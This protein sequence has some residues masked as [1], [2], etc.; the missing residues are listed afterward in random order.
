VRRYL[1]DSS[2]LAA[3]LN[4]RP[5]AVNL[6]QPWI[7]EHEAATSVLVYGEIVEYVKGLAN[8]E[9]RHRELRRLLR[10][11]YPYFLTFS[12][13]EIYADIRRQLRPPYGP[14]IIGDVDSLIAA[15]A[16]QQDL[17]LVTT[18]SDFQRVPGLKSELI[19][20]R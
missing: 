7:L 3:Y 13:M 19:S 20:L 18:D 8:F 15:T 10:E 14:G 1:L 12:I 9:V 11:V 6:I 16:I 17:T 4:E 2:P 5:A